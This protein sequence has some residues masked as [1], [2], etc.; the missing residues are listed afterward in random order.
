LRLSQKSILL[1]ERALNPTSESR[2]K[3]KLL[4]STTFKRE[5][6]KGSEKVFFLLF[7]I[8]DILKHYSFICSLCK[9]LLCKILE[10]QDKLL[11]RRWRVQMNQAFPKKEDEAYL[12]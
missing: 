6:C 11:K 8:I 5:S 4:H 12:R 1:P 9:S 7:N 2:Q 3:F 10:A